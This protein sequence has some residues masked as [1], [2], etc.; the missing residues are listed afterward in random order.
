[1]A[2]NPL[3][4][5]V[6]LPVAIGA[7]LLLNFLERRR[8][9]R[10]HV[11]SKLRR[12]ARNLTLGAGT[13]VVIQLAEVPA[14]MVLCRA[15]E[16][17]RWGMLQILDLPR[18]IEIPAA[19]ILMDYTF[20]FWH[21]LLHRVPLL[22]RFHVVHHADLDMDFSTALRFHFGEEL[23]SIPWRA[24]QVAIIGL[25]PLTFSIW[26]MAF[27]VSILFHHSEVA[28]PIEWERR[29][30]RWIVTPRMHAIHHSI[31]QEETESNWSSRLSLWDRLHR[32]LRLNVPQ[33]AISI[34]VPAWR[35]PDTVKLPDIVRMPFEPLPALWQF[36]GGGKPE[37][38]PVTGRPDQLLA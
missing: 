24:A 34:G 32:T 31:V 33:A 11:E 20:Y 14:V 28:L 36:P 2:R 9:L 16:S 17:K 4:A 22:W 26:Q 19:L 15:V 21:I 5:W 13:A 23:L 1:M 38:H 37:R 25:N 10:H 18:W 3:S 35:D 12:E 6:T 27:L 30:N 29:L 8:P 7:C